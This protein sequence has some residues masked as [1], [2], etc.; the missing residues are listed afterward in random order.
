M[1]EHRDTVARFRA[2]A[3][4]CLEASRLRRDV[5]LAPYTTC[6]IGG[7][8]DLLYDS[9]TADYLANDVETC[10][11]AELPHFILG[12]GAN[13]LVGDKGFR[14]AVIRNVARDF[15]FEGNTLWSESGAI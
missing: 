7:T 1:A 4:R 10:R 5:P 13:I 8:A 14:V 6:R 15:R 11:E 2:L 9:I 12:L 3:A